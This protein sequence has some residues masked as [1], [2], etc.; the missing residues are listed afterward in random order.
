MWD[1]Q[2]EKKTREWV[3]F[4]LLKKNFAKSYIYFYKILKKNPKF[5]N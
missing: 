2:Q 3:A 1:L 4:V 5:L